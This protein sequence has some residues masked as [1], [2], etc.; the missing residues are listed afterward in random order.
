VD[1]RVFEV[2]IVDGGSSDETPILIYNAPCVAAI[3]STK[4]R[5]HQM[6]AGAAAATG[7]LFLFLHA[8]S[9]LPLPSSSW[10]HEINTALTDPHVVGGAFRLAI[11]PS[12]FFLKWISMMANL[13]SLF[14]GLPYGDQGIFVRK[15]IFRQMGG[16]RDMP[17]MEDVEFIQRLKHYGKIVLLK[18]TISTSAR[19]WERGGA[20][21]SFRNGLL[22]ILYFLGVCPTRLARWYH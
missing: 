18:N 8:D 11:H 20:M 6:N 1:W 4:G 5:C 2:V 10:T 19:R 13:R 15:D 12:S 9:T 14:L 7:D 16:Y 22:L 17:L 21:V 3:T